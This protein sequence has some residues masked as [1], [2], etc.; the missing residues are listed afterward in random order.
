MFYPGWARCSRMYSM[1]LCSPSPGVFES[2]TITWTPG[3]S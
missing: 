2:E 1:I 3:Q